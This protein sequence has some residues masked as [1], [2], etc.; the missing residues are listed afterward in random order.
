LAPRLFDGVRPR[1]R[2]DVSR[3]LIRTDPN[4]TT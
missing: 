2:S 3:M 1:R 4:E